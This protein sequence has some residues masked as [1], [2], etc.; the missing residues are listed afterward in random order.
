MLAA[1]AALSGA[2][3]AMAPASG[4]GGA[5]PVPLFGIKL[6][7][8]YRDW[9]L[10]SVA[11]EEGDLN[12]LRAILGNDV[13]IKAYREGTLPFPDGAIIAR[14]AWRYVPSEENNKVFGRDQSFVA[15]A[16]TNVQFMVKDARKFAATGGWGFAQ[17]NDGKPV[18]DAMLGACFSC[19]V[20][21]EARDFVFTRY[22][23]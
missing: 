7:P 5:E 16:P 1:V 23:P 10:I 13:A 21:V 11:H 14:L 19:H 9:R 18:D 8:G 20:P 17:F 22:A 4:Q 6:P 2:P 15:G 3:A 12:D